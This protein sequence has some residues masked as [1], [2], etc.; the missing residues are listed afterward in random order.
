MDSNAFYLDPDEQPS[1]IVV[2]SIGSLAG[3]RRLDRRHGRGRSH[4]RDRD[5]G[6]AG[7]GGVAAR[8]ASR[9][10]VRNDFFVAN[11]VG[12][13]ESPRNSRQTSRIFAWSPCKTS[14]RHACAVN[15][16]GDSHAS[17]E[18]LPVFA[19]FRRCRSAS[20]RSAHRYS[21]S[22]RYQCDTCAN[23]SPRRRIV[24]CP[25]ASS[26]SRAAAPSGLRQALRGSGR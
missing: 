18:D 19:G 5:A 22:S 24:R 7:G 21:G 4:R 23:A 16:G 11:V 10:I 17:A 15:F 2:E 20:T 9:D 1:G 14:F 6:V 8:S 13:P 3:P 25:T 26:L 12:M